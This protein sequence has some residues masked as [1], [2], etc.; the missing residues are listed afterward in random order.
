MRDLAISYKSNHKQRCI[1]CMAI[2]KITETAAERGKY[3][4]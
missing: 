2:L 4:P 3:E 1:E